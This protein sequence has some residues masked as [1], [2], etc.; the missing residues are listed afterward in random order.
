MLSVVDRSEDRAERSVDARRAGTQLARLEVEGQVR[1]VGRLVERFAGSAGGDELVER[2][3]HGVGSA[4]RRRADVPDLEPL[5]RKPAF[6]CGGRREQLAGVLVVGRV[7]E[8]LNEAQPAR[9]RPS[10][11]RSVGGA[12]S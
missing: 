7:H 9:G 6:E 8:L 1:A 11:G 4:Q 12:V 2:G 10:G 3:P 5:G